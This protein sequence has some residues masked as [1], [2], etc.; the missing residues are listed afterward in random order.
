MDFQE[1]CDMERTTG[2]L[3]EGIGPL[4]REVAQIEFDG[5]LNTGVFENE[6]DDIREACR[7]A[8]VVKRYLCSCVDGLLAES[9]VRECLFSGNESAYQVLEA[10]LRRSSDK[11]GS[12]SLEDVTET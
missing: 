11:F 2:I 5:R 6:E 8:N 12:G 3:I 1:F 9:C 4:L 7:A 10:H